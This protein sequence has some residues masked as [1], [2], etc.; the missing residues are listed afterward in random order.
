M[1]Q[2]LH[3]SC[4]TVFIRN[5]RS[6]KK[7]QVFLR[8]THSPGSSLSRSN[9][10]STLYF[11]SC[12]QYYLCFSILSSALYLFIYWYY[13]SILRS[14]LYFSFVFSTHPFFK[15]VKTVKLLEC[16][17]SQ[18]CESSTY[19]ERMD[20]RTIRLS[21]LWVMLC[22]LRVIQHWVMQRCL[23]PICVSSM[24]VGVSSICGGLYL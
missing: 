13:F 9:L 1:C 19:S 14:A 4:A 22:H 5:V 20:G 11:P 8:K 10:A 12:I 24:C 2:G 18:L 3:H 16:S 23:F 7:F 15:H 6:I 21:H 17:V